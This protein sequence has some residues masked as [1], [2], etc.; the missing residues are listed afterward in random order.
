M[1][2]YA[3]VRPGRH[4]LLLSEFLLFRL[5]DPDVDPRDFVGA[6]RAAKVAFA[7]NRRSPN[8]RLI[9]NK[10]YWDSILR[11]LGFDV[12]EL[13]ASYGL[14]AGPAYRHLT[15]RA[16]VRRFLSHEARYPLFG[17]PAEGQASQ[18]V[19]ALDGL[20][21]DGEHLVDWSGNALERWRLIRPLEK[22]FQDKGYL[23]QSAVRQHPAVEAVIGRGVGCLRFVTFNSESGVEILGV[24]WKVPAAGAISD[25]G[26]FGGMPAPLDPETGTVI[27]FFSRSDAAADAIT[28]HPGT[29]MRLVGFTIPNWARIVS[30]VKAAAEIL[31]GLPLVGWDVAIGPEGPVFIEANSSPSFWAMQIGRQSG[32][33]TPELRSRFRIEMA[34]QAR[35][36]GPF[37]RKA[38]RVARTYRFL[39][40]RCFIGN[41]D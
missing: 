37:V 14:S 40:G 9:A 11:G 19:M 23:F 17:K 4:K 1:R 15:D 2:A 30:S 24:A 20:S 10:L 5:Y 22:R 25:A 34:R 26:A 6:Y 16:G 8:R 32:I 21:S 35:L 18:F 41:D 33:Y 3:R 7:L 38:A 29:G 31:H 27:S 36:N 12:P 28:H 39:G 13:Q